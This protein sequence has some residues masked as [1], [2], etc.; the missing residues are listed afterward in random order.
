MEEKDKKPKGGRADSKRV[1]EI[2]HKLFAK[3]KE[4]G[5]TEAE[6]QAAA[7]M[8]QRL[9]AKH[10]ITQ[11]EVELSDSIVRI[12][13][14]Y[15]A[16]M[17]YGVLPYAFK[18]GAVIAQNF[19]CQMLFIKKERRIMFRGH[20]TDALIA[21]KTFQ[22]LH[23]ICETMTSAHIRKMKKETGYERGHG[24]SFKEG[25]VDGVRQALE[26]NV[27]QY[28]LMVIMPEDVKKSVEGVRAAALPKS[29]NTGFEYESYKEGKRVGHDSVTYGRKVDGERQKKIKEVNDD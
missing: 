12:E 24:N 9:M 25:F 18:L 10:G 7:Q 8:A 27:R 14:I 28:A 13:K 2:I 21:L 26:E 22:E 11:E 15:D 4:H 1:L 29:Q 16:W 19:R 6:A 3:T 20:Q 23:M 17:E 5:A